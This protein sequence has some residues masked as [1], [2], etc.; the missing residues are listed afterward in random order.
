MPKINTPISNDEAEAW[1]RRM[2]CSPEDVEQL[3]ED[4]ELLGFIS[5]KLQTERGYEPTADQ[6]GR[7][8]SIRGE[9]TTNAGFTTTY[10]FPV[11]PAVPFHRDIRTGRR[12]SAADAAS[13]VLFWWL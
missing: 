4:E 12:I 6:L 13:R 9:I 8:W 7:M 11:A 5:S 1:V 2:L 3:L 10:P